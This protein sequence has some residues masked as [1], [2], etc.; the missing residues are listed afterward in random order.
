MAHDRTWLRTRSRRSLPAQNTCRRLSAIMEHVTS[1]SL[2]RPPAVR[3]ST[4][5]TPLPWARSCGSAARSCSSPACSRSTSRCAAPRPSSG[6]RETAQARRA[7][8]LGEHDHPG[9][10]QLHLPVRRLRRRA[11]AGARA[12]SWKPTDWGMV[13]WFFLTYCHGRRSSSAARSSSTRNLVAR[14]HHAQLERLRLGLLHHHRLPRPPRHRRP[15]R[16]PARRSAAPSPSRTSVTRRRRPPSSCRTTGTSSTWSGSASSSSSTFSSRNRT[17]PAAAC[18]TD[19]PSPR[20][21]AAARPWR[22]SR[23]SSSV[24]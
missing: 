13:E 10:V 6:R 20:R 12:P 19:T 22:P 17:A 4:G 15:H 23:S 9:A 24:S 2:S 5:R 1:T 3:S 16:L 7:V 21:P 11:P 18:S 14:G 8:R